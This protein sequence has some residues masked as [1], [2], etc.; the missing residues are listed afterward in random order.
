MLSEIENKY[1]FQYPELYKQLEADGRLNVGQYGP[2]WYATV[3]PLLKENPT[4]L[5]FSNEFELTRIDDIPEEIE[6]LTAPDDYRGIKREYRFIPFA[7]TGAG[8]NYCFFLN[9]KVGDNIPIVLL[10]HDV[11]KI[12]FLAK[13]LQDFIFRMILN[14]MSDLNVDS[15][16]SDAEFYEQLHKI[17]KTHNQYLTT[18]QTGVLN[19]IV[20]REL[21][22]YTVKYQ[23]YTEDLRGLLNTEE[24]QTIITT[25][26]GYE[27]LNK[28]M[29]Y[30]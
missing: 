28:S 10:W 9:K 26:I 29:P 2:N 27:D 6:T 21:I 12:D 3:F 14:D 25:I 15:Q 30:S 18:Q 11:D 5:L 22:E 23:R 1:N 17:L 7:T 8:D 24:L 13:N 4:L 20:Q 19:E 16:I